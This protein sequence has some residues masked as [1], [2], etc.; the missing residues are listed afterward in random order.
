MQALQ[1]L[2]VR[3]LLSRGQ[4][5]ADVAATYPLVYSDAD[6]YVYENKN[7]LPRVFMVR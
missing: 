7:P 6:S 4:M 5:G 3:Y 2:G 1:V